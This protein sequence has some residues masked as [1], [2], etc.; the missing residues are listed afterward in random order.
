MIK[1]S[2]TYY[3]VRQDAKSTIDIGKSNW[4]AL[5]CSGHLIVLLEERNELR[6]K[7]FKLLAKHTDRNWIRDR[8]KK[9]RKKGP[10]FKAQWHS[11]EYYG[12]ASDK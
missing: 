2:R 6:A 8:H 4:R 11:Q 12:S 9:I 1:R 10:S 7:E 5:N 3:I